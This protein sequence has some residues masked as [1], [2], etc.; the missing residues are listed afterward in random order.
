MANKI[1]I[2]GIVCPK[3]KEFI[4]SRARHDWHTC[5]CRYSF[6]DGGFEYLRYGVKSGKPV[7]RT[8]QLRVSKIA[9]LQ[10]WN[11]GTDKYGRIPCG[12]I[13]Q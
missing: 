7:V 1:A 13:K 2:T 12:R 6:I 5:N 9:L 4:Y 3:C 10:D 8:I 11:T